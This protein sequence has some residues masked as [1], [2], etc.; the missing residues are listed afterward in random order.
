MFLVQFAIGIFALT[1]VGMALSM[2][3]ASSQQD[4]GN[5]VIVTIR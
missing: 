3:A 5:P 2:S 1:L 4:R